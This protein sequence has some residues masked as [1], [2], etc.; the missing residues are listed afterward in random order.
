LRPGADLKIYSSLPIETF[1]PQL[2]TLKEDSNFVNYTLT[3][4]TGT[5][6]RFTLKYRFKPK[7]GYSLVIE[8]GAFS[9]IYGDKNKK[10]GKK[11]TISKPENFSNLTLKVNVPDSTKMY[12]VE[13]LDD[14]KNP[15]RTDVITKKTTL[16]YRNYYVGKFT[17]RVVYDGNKNGKWDS[18]SVKDRRQP[19]NIW[20]Y[21]KVFT[22]RPNWEAE[23]AVDIPKEVTTP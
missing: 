15:L 4:D 17:L 8:E 21:D 14:N 10:Q 19:E 20:V 13:L 3:K 12:V 16:V 5:T 18:G 2:I 11:F 6:K 9:S 1:E 22:L 23:E 7:S